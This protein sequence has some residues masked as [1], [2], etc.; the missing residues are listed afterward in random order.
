MLQKVKSLAKHQNTRKF[1]ELRNVGLYIFGIIVLSVS[2]SG[3]KVIQVNYKLQKKIGVLEQQNEIKR[4][5]NENDKLR[6]KY[7]ETDQF[8]ELAARRQFG[9]A[10]PGEKVF[11]VPK[12]VAL[13]NS[14][15]LQNTVASTQTI[16]APKKV[17]YQANFDSWMDFFLHR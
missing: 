11:V 8:L 13:A 9:L 4:L 14:T 15:D 17:W 16:E 10:A 1:L 6:N 12:S 3:A 7:L 5:Q 2:W